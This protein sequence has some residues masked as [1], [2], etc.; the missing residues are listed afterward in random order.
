MGK[1]TGH[2]GHDVDGFC[3]PLLL[4][5]VQGGGNGLEGQPVS[6]IT[7]LG[8]VLCASSSPLHILRPDPVSLLQ[9]FKDLDVPQKEMSI[10]LVNVALF[11]AECLAC[12]MI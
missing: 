11:Q 1:S 3:I 8:R 10:L 9:T 4:P 12:N 2:Y 6:Y 7:S 5:C